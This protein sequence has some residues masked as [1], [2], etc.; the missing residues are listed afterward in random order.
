MLK[1]RVLIIYYGV[2]LLSN[3]VIL[4]QH[5][6]SHWDY[7][8]RKRRRVFEKRQVSMGFTARIIARFWFRRFAVIGKRRCWLRVERSLW[9]RTGSSSRGQLRD[10]VGAFMKEGRKEGKAPAKTVC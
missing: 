6:R 5:L 10:G 3:G 9:E 4:G 7:A 8:V 1:G 2:S